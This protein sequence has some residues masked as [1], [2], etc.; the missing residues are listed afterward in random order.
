MNKKVWRED[1]TMMFIVNATASRILSLAD[2]KKSFNDILKES[3]SGSLNIED[4]NVESLEKFN[5]ATELNDRF[6]QSAAFCINMWERG[7]LNFKVVQDKMDDMFISPIVSGT[8]DS[9]GEI[10]VEKAVESILTLENEPGIYKSFNQFKANLTML[11]AYDMLLITFTSNIEDHD[12][13]AVLD[14]DLPQFKTGYLQPML[15]TGKPEIGEDASVRLGSFAT[16]IVIH[17]AWDLAKTA[18]AEAG[19]SAG[20]IVGKMESR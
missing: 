15:L 9:K 13:E 8:I 20:D 16:S 19:T 1:K 2:G 14:N 12:Q 10:L 3:Y 17:V 6:L 4:M 7:L 5:L 18:A 11:L